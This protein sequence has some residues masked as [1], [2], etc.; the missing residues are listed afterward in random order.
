MRSRLKRVLVALRVVREVK[1]EVRLNAPHDEVENE[2]K[3]ELR[4]NAPH[5]DED[6]R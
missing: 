4:L 2:V 3:I 5:D 1:I 6:L